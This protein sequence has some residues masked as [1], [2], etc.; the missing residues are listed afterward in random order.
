M[1]ERD[2]VVVVGG[3]IVGLATAWTVAQ[4]RSEARVTVLEK[5]AAVGAH[6]T[7]HNSGVIH[8]GAYY[9]PGSV[10]ART[11][12]RGRELLLKFLAERRL[13]YR[14]VGKLIVA[15]APAELPALEQIRRRAEKN[16]VAGVRLVTADE[17]RTLEPEVAG[18]A[19][20]EV[21][22]AGITDYAEVARALAR[23]LSTRGHL[24]RVGA[25]VTGVT[26]DRDGVTVR[27]ADGGTVRARYLI[28]C[29]G[30]DS[31]RV[32]RCSGLDPPVRIV[33]FRGEYYWVRAA[34]RLGLTRLIYPVP[35]PGLPFLGV[36]LTLT[37]TGRIEAGPNAVLAL[38]RE[39][40]RRGTI[41]LRDLWETAS[42]PGSVRLAR[43]L[44]GTGSYEFLRSR[45][46]G[47]F[48]RD[49]ARLVPSLTA[50]DLEPGGAG[51]RAQA[52]DRRGALV[53]DFVIVNGPRMTHVLNA[54]S[55]AATSSFGLAEEIVRGLPA[56]PA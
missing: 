28:N 56:E 3:G 24:V 36:H 53:D 22:T 21:P 9:R 45:S 55:P 39:G 16:G 43:R 40:Y 12:R 27:L 11:C 26:A 17:L 10:K 23:D 52:V 33:P 47:W 7:G 44:F 14:I 29:A 54:P 18:V 41:S 19:A 13:P 32:A 20:L 46:R 49:L 42:W 5:E 38:A 2:D 8:S 35:D 31:D 48:A 4:Q 51:V 25:E 1:T 15:A 6:Q 50:D 37:I 30:L 34:R